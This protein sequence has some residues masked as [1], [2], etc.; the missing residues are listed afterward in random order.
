MSIHT[1]E[2]FGPVLPVVRADGFDEAIGL[3]NNHAYGNGTAVF[4]RDGG[5]ATTRY[6]S[7]VK[8][9]M[10]GVNVP[11]PVPVPAAHY[12]FGGW[13]DSLSG[14]T[15]AYGPDGI[16]FFTRAKVVTSRWPGSVGPGLQLAFPT[17]NS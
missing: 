9:G 2:I 12:S 5:A 4:T 1:D 7:Q 11:V 14:D 16:N 15:H 8:V 3:V 17:A 10:V 13:T 6:A